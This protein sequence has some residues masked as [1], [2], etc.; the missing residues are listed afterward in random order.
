MKNQMK[1]SNVYGT[2]LNTSAIS[3]SSD[4][5]FDFDDDDDRQRKTSDAGSGGG[6]RFGLKAEEEEKK[7]VRIWHADDIYSEERD[8]QRVTSFKSAVIH[9]QTTAK[10][11]REFVSSRLKV[12][13]ENIDKFRIYV[14]HQQSYYL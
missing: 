7:V 9:S 3:H 13:P 14:I 1:K 12:K 2:P 8:F 4:L 5:N 10:D 11:V 6:V